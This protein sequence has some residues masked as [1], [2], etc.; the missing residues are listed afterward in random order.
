M[1][2]PVPRTVNNEVYTSM[3]QQWTEL[4]RQ[5]EAS[6]TPVPS[7]GDVLGRTMLSFILPTLREYVKKKAAKNQDIRPMLKSFFDDLEVELM[8]PRSEICGPIETARSAST[9]ASA[10]SNFNTNNTNNGAASNASS[11]TKSIGKKR[12]ESS[13]S[14]DALKQEAANG[15]TG[16]SSTAFDSVVSPPPTSKLKTAQSPTASG[17]VVI[18]R[19]DEDGDKTIE[20][21]D[22]RDVAVV[23]SHSSTG[24]ARSAS[25][26]PKPENAAAAAAAALQRT[27][28]TAI[29][30]PSLPAALPQIPGSSGFGPLSVGDRGTRQLTA[31][32]VS[33]NI[34]LKKMITITKREIIDANRD[35][36]RFEGSVACLGHV[37]RSTFRANIFFFFFAHK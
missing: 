9:T 32:V 17:V 16:A 30:T 23:D 11:L 5:H 29:A 21:E 37:E 6:G 8:N 12:K 1:P 22:S 26:V 10:N 14:G 18:K 27:M 25:L 35:Q 36:R 19:E 2:L 13:P 3:H 4:R 31:N 20:R 33:N 7:V 34:A 28:T 15:D 24:L